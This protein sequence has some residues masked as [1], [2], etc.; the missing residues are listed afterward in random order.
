MAIS[1]Q[2]NRPNYAELLLLLLLLLLAEGSL[3]M[4]FR[5]CVLVFIFF[6][7]TLTQA[8]HASPVRKLYLPERPRNALSG[9]QFL[10]RISKLNGTKREQAIV[11]E[12]LQG[13][14]P[15]FQRFLVPIEQRVKSGKYRGQTLRYWVIPDYLAIGSDHDFVRVPL[16]LRSIKILASKL[17]L[18]L[19]TTKMVDQ[20]YDQANIKLSP[21]PM[22]VRPDI[23]STRNIARHESI[24]RK[25]LRRVKP[26]PGLL[27]V[28]HKKDVVQS[29]RL[30]HKPGAIAIYGWHKTRNKPI[31]PLSTVHS[32]EYADYSHGVRLVSNTV[33]IGKKKMD[34]HRALHD[35]ALA[36][37]LSYEVAPIK[38]P[39][40]ARRRHEIVA[41]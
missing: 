16:N 39:K 12:V 11:Q 27:I 4:F 28:G 6:I 32:A 22:R 37:M 9:S 1:S 23:T 14:V 30:L 29:K 13:N 18:S 40:P 19:P 2:L 5:A 17:N 8:L 33:E 21:R 31:Q 10:T 38:A 20:I 41:H 26:R 35:K 34:L 24:V 25:Q 7:M 36:S 15:N 3:N